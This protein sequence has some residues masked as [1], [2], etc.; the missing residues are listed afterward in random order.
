MRLCRRH[1]VVSNPRKKERKKMQMRAANM[2]VR[3]ANIIRKS[4]YVDFYS[5]MLPDCIG[6]H[7][8][9]FVI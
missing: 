9:R 5:G 4:A 1:G 7:T 3:A 6:V 8:E 2:Q